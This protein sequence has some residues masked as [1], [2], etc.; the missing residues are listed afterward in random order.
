MSV[1]AGGRLPL[2]DGLVFIRSIF[3]R[4]LG[5]GTV[6]PHITLS[7]CLCCS[8]TRVLT[9]W[10]RGC[11]CAAA[12]LPGLVWPTN[13]ERPHACERVAAIGVAEAAGF[14]LAVG[15]GVRGGRRRRSP[16]SVTWPRFAFST[17]RWLSEPWLRATHFGQLTTDWRSPKQH[18][19]WPWVAGG[20]CH[21]RHPRLPRNH[22]G[23][24]RAW[25][26]CPTGGKLHV[27]V[28]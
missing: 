22:C 7:L 5:D 6:V 2:T 21:P 10:R 12:V 8:R 4:R 14:R 13:P 18:G 24:G 11:P 16:A 19:Q 23:R 20:I 27:P 17:R 15:A 9:K 1:V 25:K 26:R 28:V 3:V